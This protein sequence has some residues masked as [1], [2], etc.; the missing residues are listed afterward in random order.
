MFVAICRHMGSEASQPRAQPLIAMA[1]C[2]I[3][4]CGVQRPAEI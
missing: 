3:M 2:S 4:P 1:D